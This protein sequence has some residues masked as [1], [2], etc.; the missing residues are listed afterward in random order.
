MSNVIKSQISANIS[1]PFVFKEENNVS[2]TDET[3]CIVG[4]SQQGPAFVPQQVRSFDSDNNILNTWENVFGDFDSQK[5]DPG[6]I[7]ARIWLENGKNQVSYV[8]V[9][10]S[11]ESSDPGF[12]VGDLV[13]SGSVNNVVKGESSFTNSGGSN[14]MVH[15]LTTVVK[16]ISET[17][18]VS[19]YTDYLNQL[20]I[21]DDKAGIITDFIMPS[22]GVSLYLQN[23]K[24]DDINII[25][26]KKDLSTKLNSAAAF[27]GGQTTTIKK[28]MIY[29]QGLK[30]SSKNVLKFYDDISLR[31]GFEADVLNTDLEW[32]LDKGH[33]VYSKYRNLNSFNKA[34]VE[35]E[36]KH[37]L[38][39]SKDNIN[40]EYEDF[41]SS[42]KKAKT[43]WIV[44]QPI[45][46]SGLSDESK[47]GLHNSC[48]KLFRFHA[49]SDGV[50][51][52]NIRFRIM[53]RRKGDFN[54][55]NDSERWSIFDIDLFLIENNIYVKK[56]SFR[57]ITLNPR[58]KNYICNIIG[59]ERDFY[60][61]STKKVENIGN[62][63]KTNNFVYVEVTND[64]EDGIINSNL[65]PCGFM[66]YPRLN[67]NKDLL[68][69]P[70]AFTYPVIQNPINYVG[71]HLLL[72]TDQN[73]FKFGDRHWGV[74]FDNVKKTTIKNVKISGQNTNLL[75]DVFSKR[76][77]NNNINILDYSI[78]FKNDYTDSSKNIWVED[79]TD[80]TTDT[81]N[82]FFHLEKVLYAYSEDT[83]KSMWDFSFYQR[84][85]R[86]IANISNVSNSI[87]KYVNI[88]ELMTSSTLGDSPHGKFLHFD[89][90]TYGGFD[91]LNI[92]DS[93]KRDN[94]GISIIRELEGEIANK[95][96]GQIYDAYDLASSIVI[97][98]ENYRCDIFSMPGISHIELLKKVL[99][100]ANDKQFAFVADIPERVFNDNSLNGN[101]QSVDSYLV[102]PV[103]FNNK[104]NRPDNYQDE[105]DDL[106][107]MSSQASDLTI[108]NFMLQNFHSEYGLFVLNSIKATDNA[109]EKFILPSSILAINAIS[110]KAEQEPIDSD[111]LEYPTFISFDTVINKHYIYNNNKF[112]SL[113]ERTKEYDVAINPVG[114]MS[115]N[116][117]LKL[118]SGNTAAKNNKSVMKLFHNVRI[119]QR[120]IRELRN[121]LTREPIFQG[122]SL[123]FA[124]NSKSTSLFNTKSILLLSLETLLQSFV[125]E[126]MIKDFSVY[127]DIA[128]LDKQSEFNY[129]N[130]IIFGEI[131]FSLFDI[132]SNNTVV[133]DINKLL[134]N[135]KEFTSDNSVNI[136][137]TTI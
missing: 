74:L 134:N 81:H 17:N 35:T 33:Y 66:P 53:P 104:N 58:D 50:S 55:N 16:P 41:T 76:V 40:L 124:N 127:V 14:G 30:D 72:S 36:I 61:T 75:F 87:Y 63:R 77:E 100:K 120:V 8:R 11:L 70:D 95:T 48:E 4:T 32:I 82:S 106:F 89:L 105:R 123:L 109:S 128:D 96:Q 22:H 122:N 92:L 73:K 38:L 67:V 88:D 130:S 44:S 43:P 64:I 98:D 19:P 65:M 23:N 39:K 112:D 21:S 91:G 107:Y 68:D 129:V 71:N 57:N 52:N 132:G 18:V 102:D 5:T 54:S 13:L 99:Q 83:I 116:K 1:T 118:L 56:E 135:I 137:N 119:K 45:N 3:L 126:G 49:Y 114:I 29:I 42:F 10:G 27:L 90:M 108:D 62:Y 31:Q 34:D 97:D 78:Y 69:T 133:L 37:L 85:G 80:N 7:A 110:L 79:L 51:G 46:R 125:D 20:N 94:H 28:P 115:S 111:E 86:S 60:N 84:D 9:L 131:S 26:K 103:L 101:Y 25:S 93:Y 15:F 121:L 12:K 136:I 6:P 2:L 24:V 59:T 47:V 117:Q 113:I